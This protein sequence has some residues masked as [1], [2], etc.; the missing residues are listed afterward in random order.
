MMLS[1]AGQSETAGIG[2]HGRTNS[3]G[4]EAE[5]FATLLA[6]GSDP[7]VKTAWQRGEHVNH[8][9]RD[10]TQD[11]VVAEVSGRLFSEDAPQTTLT[12]TKAQVASGQA[13][14]LWHEGM[15]DADTGQPEAATQPNALVVVQGLGYEALRS[16][17]PHAIDNLK[18]M[19]A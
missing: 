5:H 10:N 7:Q 12:V 3:D 9:W 17:S 16:T 4:I 1:A 6:A 15:R 8:A 18:E 11:S 14:L 19:I 2:D 13:M